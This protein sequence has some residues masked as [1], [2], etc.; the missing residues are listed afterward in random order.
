MAALHALSLT[1]VVRRTTSGELS[2]REVAEAMVDRIRALDGEY[3]AYQM[4]YGQAA[5]VRADALDAA[6]R[7]GGKLGILHGAPI[8]LKDLLDTKDIPTAG[9]TTVWARRRPAF[10]ATVVTRLTEAG[11]L[12]LGKTKLTEGAYALHHPDVAPPKNPWNPARWCGVSSSGSG[13]AV[14]AGLAHGATGSDTGGSIRFPSASCGL[15]GVKPTYGRVSRYGV[16]PLADSL[17]HL[18][19]MT[20][21]VADARRMLAAMSGFDENDPTSHGPPTHCDSAPFDNLKSL[22]VAVDEDWAGTAADANAAAAI[23]AGL[24]LCRNAGTAI[25]PLRLP[26]TEALVDGWGTTCGVECAIAHAESYRREPE[27][28]GPALASLIEAGLSASATDYARLERERERF[29]AGLDAILTEADLLLAPCMP[30]PVPAA[31]RSADFGRRDG[32]IR[33]TAPFDYSGHPS[34]TLPFAVDEDNVPRAFQLIGRR[35]DDDRLLAI[36]E[37]IEAAAGFGYPHLH[38]G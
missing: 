31:E 37:T 22:I 34:V 36:A 30:G 35:M 24:R 29:R 18:G 3:G 38:L 23:E 28:Y 33:F 10:D 25:R 16:L 8:A 11:A 21:S 5:L 6:K 13:V 20:R 14:A 27:A 17:D 2:V 26:S 1:E 19:P 32:F 7:R 9:G 12:V 4:A 15:V